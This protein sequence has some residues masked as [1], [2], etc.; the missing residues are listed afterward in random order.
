[1]P[2]FVPG[3][4]YEAVSYTHL[5]VYKRQV[6]GTAAMLDGLCDRI[7]EELGRSVKTVVA[8]GGLA[9]EIVSNCKRKVLYRENLLLEGLKLIYDKNTSKGGRGMQR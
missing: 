7:E 8:T 4:R 5:D 3:C 1:M 9:K 6:F 2:V